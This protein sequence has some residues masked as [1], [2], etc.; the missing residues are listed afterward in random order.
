MIAFRVLA[1]AAE[2]FQP[3][4]GLGDAALDALGA[5]ASIAHRSPGFPCR[6]SLRDA[7]IGERVILLN[8]EHLGGPTPYRSRHA[9]FV[10]EG[11]TSAAPDVNELPDYLGRRLL[12]VRAFDATDRMLGADV[13][14]GCESRPLFERLLGMPATRFLHVHN[15]REGC[16]LARVERA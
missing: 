10:R 5:T 8:F 11:A 13:V 3:L 14:E 1:L 9:I 7:A 16:Y 4:Y 6:V 2:P 12:S 15:A